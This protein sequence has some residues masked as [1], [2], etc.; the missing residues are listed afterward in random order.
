MDQKL[1]AYVRAGMAKGFSE[2]YIA[3]VLRRHGHPEANISEAFSRVRPEPKRNHTLT[4][5]MAVG[6][7]ALLFVLLFLGT[8]ATDIPT[9]AV[10]GNAVNDLQGTVDK[11]ALLQTQ[12]D[13]QQAELDAAL[14][15]ANNAE[16][17]SKEK[18]TLL[19]DLQAY[20]GAVKH[21][22]EETRNALFE[23]WTFLFSKH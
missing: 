15:R 18:E 13:D 19:A 14:E 1:E 11:I 21:E 3:D 9:A 23:L 2:T 7:L 12:V 22:R 20:Y 4:A 6:A 5:S 17:S 16:L 8:T 10:T